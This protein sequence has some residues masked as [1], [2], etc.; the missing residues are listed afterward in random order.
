MTAWVRESGARSQPSGDAQMRTLPY[1][2]LDHVRITETFLNNPTKFL[3]HLI[4]TSR[5]SADYA[6]FTDTEMCVN[7]R[8][9][10][11]SFLYR[12]RAELHR[13]A[14]DSLRYGSYCDGGRLNRLRGRKKTITARAAAAPTA[15]SRANRDDC[16]HRGEN[17][18]LESPSLA[19]SGQT[20]AQ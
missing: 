4:G 7:L 16:E 8:N 6:D 13:H 5:E 12:Y 10:R 20:H 3:R 14:A 18:D 2:E 11:T 1:E 15:S 9:L 19:G 17:R